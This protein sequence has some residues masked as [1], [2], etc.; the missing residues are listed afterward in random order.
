LRGYDVVLGKLAATSLNAFYGV[1]AMVPMLAVPLLLGGVTPGEFERMAL[2]ILDTLFFSLTLGICVSAVSLSARKAVIAT[3]LALTFF[4]AVLP[5]CSE[6]VGGVGWFHRY[7]VM[8][9][10]GFA[11]V[12]AFDA[13]YKT[14]AVDFWTSLALIHALGWVFLITASVVAPRS[15]RDR[16]AIAPGRRRWERWR[17]W[18]LGEPGERRAFRSRL[19]GENAYYWLAAR[20][21]TRVASVWAALG[22]VTG[23]WAWGLARYHRD[24]LNPFMY[25]LTCV[26]LNMLIKLWVA[27][28]AGRQLAEDRQDG[29][30]ELLLSTPL[31][32]REILRGQ[33]LA[34]QRQFLGPIA[35]T[36]AAFLVFLAAS[37]S[38]TI[39][40]VPRA[41]CVWVYAAAMIGLAADVAA[42]HWTGMWQALTARNP[43]RAALGTVGRILVLPWLGMALALFLAA[44]AAT[45]AQYEPQPGR[46]VAL[47]LA[48]G[49]T[50]DVGFAAWS[51]HQLYTRFRRAAEQRY[52]PAP[53]LWKRWIRTAKPATPPDK[54]LPASAPSRNQKGGS[55]RTLDKG[56]DLG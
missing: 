9:S 20:V 56:F 37:L 27:A 22:I 40:E 44:L 5:L 18:T 43:Q 48:L 31:T 2:V 49:L 21:R 14:Q 51:R 11:Y 17:L 13:V 42:L 16:P 19:L 55:P 36:L 8:C 46:V 15:W 33:F 54:G 25:S 34:L 12:V 1:L 39:E 35:V 3:L 32:V 28:E 7:A 50:T 6:W 29:T 45:V 24:W 30:L 10:P 53:G 52:T 26:C 38:D 47:W 23:A 41:F 4:T